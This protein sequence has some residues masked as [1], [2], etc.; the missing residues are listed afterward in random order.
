[1]KLWA[2]LSRPERLRV[3]ALLFLAA[4]GSALETVSVATI[5]PFIALASN[6]ESVREHPSLYFIY[7]RLK[8]QSPQDFVFALGAG[9]VGFFVFKCVYLLFLN[10]F[11]SKTW[12]ALDRDIALRLLKKI[13]FHPYRFFLKRNSA[14]LYRTLTSDVTQTSAAI[15]QSMT[16][17]SEF[18][19]IS[20]I[21]LVLVRAQPQVTLAII[22]VSTAM[23]LILYFVFQAPATR[24]GQVAQVE[25]GHMI[26]AANESFGA[27]KEIKLFGAEESFISRYTRHIRA[28]TNE[29]IRFEVMSGAPKMII[30]AVAFCGMIGVILWH[31][32]T[33]HHLMES[34]S[35]LAL[36]AVAGYKIMPSLNKILIASITLNRAKASV[37]RVFLEFQNNEAELPAKTSNTRLQ[38]LEALELQNVSFEFEKGTSILNNLSIKF[39]KGSMTGMIGQSGAGKTTLVDIL[40]G[41]L[42]PQKGQILLDGTAI[43]SG[44]LR[45]YQKLFGYV[46]QF[47]YLMDDTVLAN[48][49]FG[50]VPEKNDLERVFRAAKLAQIHDFIMSLPAGY[51]TRMGERGVRFS[52]GQRQRL[53]IV[54]ALYRDPE[55]LVLDEA[56][57]SLDGPTENEFLEAVKSLGKE[58]TIIMIAH[59]LSTLKDCDQIYDVKN[60]HWIS[61]EKL[62]DKTLMAGELHI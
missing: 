15:N 55:I 12:R 53:G 8:F 42:S 39:R 62:R 30:E 58:K 1:M 56:T 28:F 16:W 33:S 9:L 38:L 36:Y 3:F 14:E 6:A 11:Q 22:L 18:L 48:I 41:I 43:H 60:N 54:R 35:L 34:L 31:L 10:F 45:A 26:Q 7:E 17:I 49:R 29:M 4:V 40:M 25:S 57:S 27:I 52:G 21:L 24:I 44:N 2:L 37:E 5:L 20:G 32:K 61:K 23:F 51:E 50:E 46:P 59:R 47:I 19:V 13:L